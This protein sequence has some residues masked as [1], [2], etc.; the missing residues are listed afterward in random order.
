MFSFVLVGLLT[1]MGR[2]KVTEH[3]LDEAMEPLGFIAEPSPS[4]KALSSRLSEDFC[5]HQCQALPTVPACVRDGRCREIKEFC[6]SS[7]FHGTLGYDKGL[8]AAI[9]G[10]WWSCL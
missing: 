5:R 4:H 9:P 3:A 7:P 6:R 2:V 10:M 8:A 1:D